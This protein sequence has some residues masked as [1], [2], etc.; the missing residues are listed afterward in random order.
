MGPDAG[1]NDVI[2]GA[3]NRLKV[4]PFKEPVPLAVVTATAPEDPPATIA[5]IE[6]LE[7]TVKN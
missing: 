4:K 2:T 3:G 5:V 1:E 7:L 6:K